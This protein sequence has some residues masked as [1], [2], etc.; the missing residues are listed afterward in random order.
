MEFEFNL[1]SFPSFENASKGP[2]C[3]AFG[4]WKIILKKNEVAGINL[5]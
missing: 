4:L 5:L 2:S 1:S 3:K